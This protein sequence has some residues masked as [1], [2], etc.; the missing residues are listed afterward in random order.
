M[1][2]RSAADTPG[3]PANAPCAVTASGNVKTLSTYVS[4]A[5][6]GTEPRQERPKVRATSLP[7][8]F[9]QLVVRRSR[10][11]ADQALDSGLVPSLDRGMPTALELDEASDELHI[12]V[13]KREQPVMEPFELWRHRS[14]LRGY[15]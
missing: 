15:P 13:D 10:A 9:R 12:A 5:G 4:N 3:V 8:A 1:R 7:S 11:V 2:L 6:S 14:E